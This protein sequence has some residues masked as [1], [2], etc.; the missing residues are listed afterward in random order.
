MAGTGDALQSFECWRRGE[1]N[2][3]ILN[4]GYTTQFYTVCQELGAHGLAIS[5]NTRLG[6]ASDGKLTVEHRGNPFAGKQGLGYHA[7]HVACAQAVLDDVRRFEANVVIVEQQPHLPLLSPL[8]RD[9]KVAVVQAL[10]CPL[11]PQYR[12]NSPVQSLL[13]G[14]MSDFY[15]NPRAVVMSASYDV[16]RQ[17]RELSGP[18]GCAVVEFL[19]SYRT[20]NFGKVE[21]PRHE[22]RPFRIFFAGRIESA[23]GI[24]E[25]LEIA[26]RIR[27][28]GRTDISFDICG[29]GSALPELK[30]RAQQADIGDTMAFHGWCEPAVMRRYLDRSHAVIVPTNR[31]YGEGFNQVVVEGLLAGRPVLTSEICPAVAYVRPAVLLHEPED[32]EA[33]QRSIIALADDRQ[34]YEDL[35]RRAAPMTRQFLDDEYSFAA[36]LR[37][38]LPSLAAGRVPPSRAVPFP[39]V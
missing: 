13:L 29:D 30:Q 26:R 32:V 34:R 1:E 33:Y 37:H 19:P 35:Q 21:P 9:G 15:R 17:I 2:R 6:S 38:L 4:V 23:K 18:A 31:E 14:L 10:H 8:Y 39:S 22:V 16:T 36:A 5:T 25:L 12:K 7:Q 20:Q 11:W 28:S 3:A 27:A 24:F